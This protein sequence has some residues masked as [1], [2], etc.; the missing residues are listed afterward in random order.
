MD[1]DTRM[2]EDID[3]LNKILELND[4]ELSRSLLERSNWDISVCVLH[5]FSGHN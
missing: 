5:L 2:N 1:D 3:Q 4:Y